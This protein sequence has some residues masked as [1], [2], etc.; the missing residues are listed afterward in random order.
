MK[1]ATL[2]LLVL[3][4][5]FTSACKKKEAAP[6]VPAPAPEPETAQPAEPTGPAIPDVA[7]TASAS[8]NLVN[9]F[10][11]GV[12][13]LTEADDAQAGAAVL[14]GMLDKYDVAELRAKSKA[15]KAAGQGASDEVKA[16]FKALKAEYNEVSTK[17]G[18]SDP[19]AFG[20][21]A[22]AWAAAWGLN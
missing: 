1:K 16:K 12:N 13:A 15:A 8:E 14:M 6:E 2:A 20:E 3:A 19:Q 21:A 17:L 4:M 22:K 7:L 11:A 10:E 18:A 5:A 9:V